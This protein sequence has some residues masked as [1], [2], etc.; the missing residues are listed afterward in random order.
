MENQNKKAKKLYLSV[1]KKQICFLQN[2][3]QAFLSWK[4]LEFRGKREFEGS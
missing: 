4:S 1:N 2:I 3:L